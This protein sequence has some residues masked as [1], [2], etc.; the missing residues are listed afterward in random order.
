MSN[1][2]KKLLLID[3]NSVAFRAFYGLINV[4]NKFV[5]HDGLHTNAIY[6][7]K[8]M[9]DRLL[10]CKQPTNVL[11]AFDAGRKTFRTK[12]YAEYKAQR[13]KAPSALLEQLP[14][15]RQMLNAYGIKNY[16]LVDY[17]ADDIIGTLAKRAENEGYT[18]TIVTG[19]HDLTQLATSKTTVEITKKGV[20]ELQD[21]TPAYIEKEYGVTPHQ[22]IDMKALVGDN[23]DNYPG[24]TKI[25]EKTALRLLKKYHSVEGI[26]QHIDEM[27]PSKMKEHLIADKE[28]AFLCKDLATIRQDAPVTI[29]LTDTQWKGVHY[30]ELKEFFRQMDFNQF[31]SKMSVEYQQQGN[32]Y[33][34]KKIEYTL[35][36]KD[37]LDTL[38]VPADKSVGFYLEINGDNYHIAPLVGFAFKI[39]GHYYASKDVSLLQKQP[40]KDILENPQLTLDVFNSKRTYVGLHRLGIK[41][42][43]IDFDLLLVSYLLNN[44]DNS[45][46]LG[47]LAQEHHYYKVQTDED[48]YGKGVKRT[49]PSDDNIFLEHLCHKVE[50][51][52][53]LKPELMKNIHINDQDY[54]YEK[55][56]RPLSIILSNMEITGIKVDVE[57]LKEMRSE[58]KER[59]SEIEQQIYQEAG[60]EF[61]IGSP[62]QLGKILFEKLKLPVIKKT[63]TGY[64]TAVNI[65]EQLRGLSPIIDN[66]LMYRQLSK[67]QST[68]VEGLLEDVY[69]QDSKVHT[70]YTQTLTST[71][72]LSS[73]D[74]NLQNIPV[75]MEEGRKIRQAFVPSHKGWKIFSSDYSQV[76][77]R[78]LASISGDKN[79]QEAFESG[80]DIHAN[81][82]M[83]VFELSSPEQV[84]PNMRRQAKA[85]N[86]GIVYGISDYGLSKDIGVSRKQ[87]KKFIETYFKA[88]PGVHKYMTGIVALAKKQ[89]YVETLYHRR[90]YLPDINSK[91]YNL[92]SFAERTAMNAPIQGSAADIIKIAMINMEKALKIK[93][94]K[95]RMLLQVHDE[96]IFEAPKEEIPILAKLVPNIMDSAVKLHVPLKVESAA[97]ATWFDAKK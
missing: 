55:I 80:A 15:L 26:Y 37:N 73:V 79:M 21:C 44:I 39:N 97:G 3:G 58:F 60:E 56:E 4:V 24:V 14:Y 46:D 87:A 10:K 75:R 42:T 35:L 81:T 66:I 69:P 78:V 57:R 38:S 49:L 62:K 84:T 9:L 95:A 25:G 65:L 96:L 12:E 63:K 70:R 11:V 45:E 89:G 50:A 93:K 17:E 74:P 92:R 29:K 43:K 64:S 51:I 68:Y 40:L 32:A 16:D 20:T 59:L 91:N 72:R 36:T 94:L 76:E 52:K 53:D 31:L 82:A 83:K 13:A 90:R 8:I 85:V 47:K 18:T 5:N 28:M 54:L 88:F 23:S 19:D 33:L 27:Q 6:S 30:D 77:L 67:L 61:N 1:S 7:F 71:G 2:A 22:I 41:M 34:V 48:V 86:F